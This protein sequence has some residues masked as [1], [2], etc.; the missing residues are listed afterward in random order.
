MSRLKVFL[1]TN[2]LASYLLGKPEAER[3]FD[4]DVAKRVQY[5]ISPVVLQ[6][7]L[8]VSDELGK[9][10]NSEELNRL[11]SKY[12]TIKELDE[13]TVKTSVQRI[14]QLRNRIV[15]ANDLLNIQV[16]ATTTDYFLTQDKVLLSLKDIG[17]VKVISPDQFF[18]LVKEAA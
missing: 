6:E 3:L 11:L 18:D 10:D 4:P 15:H 7:L 14:R 2:V 12:L 5:I 13:E 17:S 9:K 1:D 8:L 16:A